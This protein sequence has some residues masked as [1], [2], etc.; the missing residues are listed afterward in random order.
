MQPVST[1]AFCTWGVS[2]NV[3]RLI[4]DSF[5]KKF[6]A[7]ALFRKSLLSLQ[8]GMCVDTRKLSDII[9]W[10]T[11]TT[12]CASGARVNRDNGKALVGLILRHL[13]VMISSLKPIGPRCPKG[14][15][16][17]KRNLRSTQDSTRDPQNSTKGA[18]RQA[19]REPKCS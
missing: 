16:R 5:T 18:P 6:L 1:Q 10:F 4:L 7:R 2:F 17:T 3:L 15:A 9:Q 8:R 19:H 12:R 13:V 14:E 11:N